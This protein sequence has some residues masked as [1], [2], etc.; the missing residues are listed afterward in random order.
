MNENV[1][2]YGYEESEGVSLQYLSKILWNNIKLILIITMWVIVIGVVYTF[3][4]V[5]PKYTA[6]T[7]LTV[8][9]D[10][11]ATQTNEQSAII[12]A[13][14]LIGTYEEFIVSNKVLDSVIEDIPELSDTS[15][16]TIRNSISV[17]TISQVL[18]IHISV[19]SESPELAQKLANTIVN[20]SI[21]IANDEND[22]YVFLQNKLKV[23]DEAKLPE[24]P[25]SPNK[26][27]NIVISALLGG[28]IAFA[29]VYVKEFFNNKYKT[30]E[31]LENYLHI[32][33]IAIVPGT[34]KERNLVD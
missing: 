16:A 23:L 24:E 1:N 4:V 22:P 12:I 31:E 14:N 5:T 33:V 21:E 29:V 8:Q 3:V 34:I 28:I 17:S 20:N 11:E 30:V 13:N 32:K 7:S 10:I 6:Q 19:V 26:M 15:L 27:L 25:S 9:V 18:I 2:D